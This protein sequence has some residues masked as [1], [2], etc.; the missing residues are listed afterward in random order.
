MYRDLLEN[1]IIND[2]FLTVQFAFEK[3][4]RPRQ[5]DID[6]A[7]G[8]GYLK[9]IEWVIQKEI[10]PTRYG[11]TAALMLQKYDMVDLLAKYQIYPHATSKNVNIS[12]RI[13]SGGRYCID[14]NIMYEP[15]T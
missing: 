5:K 13:D 2:K 7:T 8:M 10:Y 15:L 1:A 14:I 3:G 4:D 6:Y 11:A 12:R 9:I